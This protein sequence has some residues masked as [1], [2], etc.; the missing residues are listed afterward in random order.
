MRTI[1]GRRRPIPDIDST[2]QFRR[3]GAER[4]A[5]NTPIQGAA[6]DLIKVAMIDIQ[7]EIEEKNFGGRMILQV[8]DE[9][10]F[11]VPVGEKEVFGAMVREKM[12]GAIRL[13]VPI[14]VD[15]GWGADWG[16]AH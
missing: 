9:L 3:E 14:V 16:E 13:S 5:I 10:V 15:M 2:A 7:R 11:E 8:H 4:I 12:E 6:A 1:L